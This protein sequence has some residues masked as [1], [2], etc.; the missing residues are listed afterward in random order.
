[1]DT[2]VGWY[3]AAGAVEAAWG[4]GLVE[5]LPRAKP[6]PRLLLNAPGSAG[7]VGGVLDALA[8]AVPVIAA[9]DGS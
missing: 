5:R 8:V 3:S 1:M 6:E 4:A 9:P 2:A 7:V